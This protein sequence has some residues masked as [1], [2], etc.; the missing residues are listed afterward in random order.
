MNIFQ[1]C[2]LALLAAETTGEREGTARFWRTIFMFPHFPKNVIL[3]PLQN[4]SV[5]FTWDNRIL[6]SPKSCQFPS[7]T[8]PLK[9][10]GF[11]PEPQ[12]GHFP[13]KRFPLYTFNILAPPRSFC[14][15]LFTTKVRGQ[16]NLRP[17]KLTAV[18][19]ALSR[20]R[21]SSCCY[22]PFSPSTVS[23]LVTG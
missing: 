21:M 4:P 11:V 16:I 6:S 7:V 17:R 14:L 12:L 5:I 1:Y 18:G 9:K 15:A 13:Q 8:L 3:P 10:Q 22:S 20:G 23:K 19:H 2:F